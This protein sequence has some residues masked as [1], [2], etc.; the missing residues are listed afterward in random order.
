VY[1]SW[2]ELMLWPTVSRPIGLSV[3]VSDTHL[4]PITRFFFFLSLVWQLLCPSSWGAL[5]DK[6]TGLQFVVRSV[7]GQSR[8]GA[9]T[10]H[11]CLIRDYWDP[12][13][14]PLTTRRDYGGS[15]L[16]RLHTGKCSWS[17]GSTLYRHW[18]FDGLTLQ[19][20]V[21]PE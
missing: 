12:F 15:I 4:G 6:R 8:G 14:S 2:V 21:I 1:L 13:P 11:Y 17:N 18:I 5:S 16:T 3:L 7:G 20:N 9:I 19:K 10:I